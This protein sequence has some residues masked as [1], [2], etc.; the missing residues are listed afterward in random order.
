MDT[1]DLK[2]LQ[3]DDGDF[4]VIG[5]TQR[6]KSVCI[7]RGG[8]Q[9]AAILCDNG[10]HDWMLARMQRTTG[11]G[12]WFASAQAA[13]DDAMDSLGRHSPITW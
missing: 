2:K 5:T 12:A 1:P 7:R 11:S 8:N 9:Y 10:G 3:I 6:G 13:L 4:A